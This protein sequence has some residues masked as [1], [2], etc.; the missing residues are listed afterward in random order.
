[1]SGEEN[2]CVIG[3]Q[4]R[5]EDRGQHLREEQRK[6]NLGTRQRRSHQ[7]G[8][9]ENQR[10]HAH[11]Q[12]MQQG[13]CYFSPLF[14]ASFGLSAFFMFLFCLHYWLT[15]CTPLLVGF[16][17]S[18]SKEELTNIF[19]KGPEINLSGFVGHSDMKINGL[20]C[21]PIKFYLQDRWQVKF[22]LQAVLCQLLLQGL[23]L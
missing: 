15:S 20:V 12:K 17:G 13:D 19:S 4:L 21:V 22:G 5:E 16:F 11:L 18:Y 2:A 8:K 6:W 7:S 23:H 9:K 1:M 14:L 10:E 3:R